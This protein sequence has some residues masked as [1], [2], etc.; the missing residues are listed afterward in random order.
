MPID[1][2]EPERTPQFEG[3]PLARPDEEVVDQGIA[4]YLGTLFSRRRMLT[5][6]GWEAPG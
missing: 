4:F 3:R 1:E 6:L 2:R 5:M